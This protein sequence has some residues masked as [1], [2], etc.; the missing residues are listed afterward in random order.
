MYK[1]LFFLI[2]AFAVVLGCQ[3]KAEYAV[4]E[5]TGEAEEEYGFPVL[6]VDAFF[7]GVIET[8]GDYTVRGRVKGTIIA[9]GTV[10]IDE[11]GIVE[12]DSIVA[13]DVIVKGHVTGN[14]KAINEVRVD[15]TGIVIGET[16]CKNLVVNGGS[17]FDAKS[18]MGEPKKRE[19]PR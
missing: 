6:D 13:G 15:P 8:D 14:I 11:T 18:D 4:P 9:T 2:M 17:V 12:C 3:K 5:E 7:E 19:R 1:K 16:F 10:L